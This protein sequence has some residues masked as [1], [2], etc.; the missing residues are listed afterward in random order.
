[1]GTA[2]GARIEKANVARGRWGQ[3]GH[4]ACDGGRRKEL[5]KLGTLFRSE[6]AAGISPVEIRL[7][8]EPL[9]VI[10]WRK[11]CLCRRSQDPPP[12][13]LRYLSLPSLVE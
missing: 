9:P 11:D 7:I 12:C 13:R 2:T 10:D 6:K 4:E 1:M 3:A 8:D 5:A